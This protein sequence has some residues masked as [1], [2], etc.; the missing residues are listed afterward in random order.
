MEDKKKD[1]KKDIE[2]IVRGIQQAFRNSKEVGTEIGLRSEEYPSAAGPGW[3]KLFDTFSIKIVG[4]CLYVTYCTQITLDQFH[5]MNL[6]QEV[7]GFAADAIKF[8]KTEYKDVTGNALKLTDSK[9]DPV[10]KTEHISYQRMTLY[11]TKKYIIGG[12]TTLREEDDDVLKGYRD[13]FEGYIK[14][15]KLDAKKEKD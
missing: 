14:A 13:T 3:V 12:L 6:V 11:G 15:M 5:Q 8:L 7:E 9:E 2:T 10:I 1:N 4:N